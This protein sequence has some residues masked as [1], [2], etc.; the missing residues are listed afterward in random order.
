MKH[1]DDYAATL[2]GAA[3]FALDS[4]TFLRDRGPESDEPSEMVRTGR[5]LALASVLRQITGRNIGS[6]E[7]GVRAVLDGIES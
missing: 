5:M 3:L 6:D 4:W 1:G 2:K 7:E